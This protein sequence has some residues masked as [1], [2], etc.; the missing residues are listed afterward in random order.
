M[1]TRWL[2]TLLFGITATDSATFAAVAALVVAIGFVASVVP[3]RRAM[4]ADPM[5]ALRAD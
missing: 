3:A 2:D 1:L 4:K 5:E